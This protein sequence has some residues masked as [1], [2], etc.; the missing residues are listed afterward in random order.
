MRYKHLKKLAIITEWENSIYKATYTCSIFWPLQLVMPDGSLEMTAFS[1]SIELAMG[2]PITPKKRKDLEKKAF[3][4]G[5]LELEK[6]LKERKLFLVDLYTLKP[7]RIVEGFVKIK[8]FN[9]IPELWK[10]ILSFYVN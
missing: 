9:K 8:V 6:G 5:W 10:D 4:E 3:E 1:K 2:E 7:T